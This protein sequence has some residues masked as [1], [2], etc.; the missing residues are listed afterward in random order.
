MWSND[1][2]SLSSLHIHK[3]RAALLKQSLS[4][5]LR[6]TIIT[7]KDQSH[8]QAP[9]ASLKKW[10]KAQ[11]KEMQDH[12]VSYSGLAAV[13]ISLGRRKRQKTKTSY[14]LLIKILWHK[15]FVPPHETILIQHLFFIF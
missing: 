15:P 5:P 10:D 1:A 14:Y 3:N 4:T 6:I 9:D 2:P 7:Q 13:A 11:M 8:G 12:A